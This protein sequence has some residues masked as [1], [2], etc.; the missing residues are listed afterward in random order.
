MRSLHV[1]AGLIAL[2][3]GAVALSA[4]KGGRLHRRSGMIFVYTMLFMSATGALMAGLRLNW[5]TVVPGVLTF[6]LVSTALLTVRRPAEGFQWLDSAA[7]L[8]VLAVVITDVT[9]GL[10]ALASPT[11][12]R[13]GYPPPLYFIFASV[14]LLATVGDIRMLRAGGVQGARRIARHLWRMCFAMWIATASFFLGQAR[15]F[16]KPLRN[17]A[18]L[19]IP[20]LLVL[21][22]MFYWLA[23]VSFAKRRPRA[24]PWRESVAPATR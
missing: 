6:Y 3:S 7:L 24:V 9:F 10:Q 20:V 4:L 16:P 17:G 12:R 1:V 13:F 15:H 22:A 8:V 19:S 14:A 2:A 23:R 5:G 11:G 21:V 18:L